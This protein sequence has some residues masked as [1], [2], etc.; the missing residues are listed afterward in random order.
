[1]ANESL[2]IPNPPVFAIFKPI[3]PRIKLIE[4]V[5]IGTGLLSC[6]IKTGFNHIK[7]V[8]NRILSLM[9]GSVPVICPG[10]PK[11]SQKAPQM[12]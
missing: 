2:E 12:N 5:F 8:F 9:K 1:M 11:M 6:Y 7:P 3:P 10:V 4:P